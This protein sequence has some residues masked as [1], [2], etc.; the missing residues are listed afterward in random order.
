MTGIGAISFDLMRG[1]PSKWQPRVETYK[2]PGV[3][4]TGAMLLGSGD[5]GNELVTV[6][7]CADNATANA[8]IVLYRAL[9]GT[10]QGIVDDW[11]DLYYN[12]LIVDVDVKDPK[13]AAIWNGNDAAVRLEAHWKIIKMDTV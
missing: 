1:L 9:V 4:G 11:T 7:F 3:D 2:I 12:Y 6:K 13:K 8:Q 10:V 5:D